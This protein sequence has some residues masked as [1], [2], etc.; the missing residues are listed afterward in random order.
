MDKGVA[1]KLGPLGFF[2]ALWVGMMAAICGAAPAEAEV[3][4][5]QETRQ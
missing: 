1:T 3:T 5:T 4:T 2:A